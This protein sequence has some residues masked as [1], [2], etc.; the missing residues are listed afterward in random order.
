MKQQK[1]K[2]RK[3]AQKKEVLVADGWKVTIVPSEPTDNRKSSVSRSKSKSNRSKSRSSVRPKS[4]MMNKS[5]TKKSL[6]SA[7]A[8][9]TNYDNLN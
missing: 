8:D 1:L 7:F 3:E 6:R 2:E 9:I 5:S 4:A